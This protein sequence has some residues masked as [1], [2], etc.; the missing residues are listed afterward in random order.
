MDNNCFG[1]VYVSIPRL[2]VDETLS[3][4]SNESSYL[5]WSIIHKNI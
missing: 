2:I 3:F 1:D 5:F 4:F